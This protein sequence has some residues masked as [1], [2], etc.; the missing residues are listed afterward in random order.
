MNTNCIVIIPQKASIIASFSTGF[1]ICEILESQ[2]MRLINAFKLC[3]HPALD[4]I[5]GFENDMR[6]KFTNK[7]QKPQKI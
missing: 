6:Y 5:S 7:F 4:P 2:E 3:P 1:R